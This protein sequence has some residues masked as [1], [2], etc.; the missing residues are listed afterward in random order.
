VTT[1]AIPASGWTMSFIR[2]RLGSSNLLAN[3][4]YAEARP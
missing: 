3:W 1:G 4:D 2:I